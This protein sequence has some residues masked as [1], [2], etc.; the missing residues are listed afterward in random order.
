[1]SDI[2][3]ILVAAA[4]AYGLDGSALHTHEPLSGSEDQHGDLY[5]KVRI[6]DSTYSL[7]LLNRERY[8]HGVYVDLSDD[9]L[10]A[11]MRLCDFL[12]EH[13]LPFMRRVPPAN[14]YGHFCLSNYGHPSQFHQLWH[15]TCNHLIAIR[16]RFSWVFILQR[17]AA[18][19]FAGLQNRGVAPRSPARMAGRE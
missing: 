15:K 4:K 18:P 11:Q 1:M 7:R 3:P 6:G 12:A 13:D 9:V 10:S 8:A 14:N 19:D 17:L 2:P 16:L 5:F